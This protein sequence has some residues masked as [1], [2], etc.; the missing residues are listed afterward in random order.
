[1]NTSIISSQDD[2]LELC[3]HITKCGVVSFD[4]EFISDIGYR[5]QLGLL[6]FAT[7]ERCVA[8]DPLEI[9]SLDAWWD[10]M[11]DDSTTV[12][13]HGGQAEIRF[14]IQLSGKIPKRLVDI[15]KDFAA[16]AIRCHTPRLLNACWEKSLRIRRR[17]PIG[18]DDRFRPSRSNTLWKM[19]PL[20]H[21]S[22]LA[23]VNG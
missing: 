6:Q 5:P 15:Q 10:V 2:F 19:S 7:P 21:R 11:A 13:V 16:A 20:F 22:G 1:M 9:S 4:S 3:D 14:C 12:I 18:C 23:K 8:V 17:G